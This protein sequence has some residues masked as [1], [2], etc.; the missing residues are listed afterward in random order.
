M[1]DGVGDGVAGDA[2]ERG[3]RVV[4]GVLREVFR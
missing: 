1:V 4:R 2:R 3:V